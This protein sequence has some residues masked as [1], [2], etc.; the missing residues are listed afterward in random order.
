MKGQSDEEWG[1]EEWGDEEVGK[2]KRVEGRA[3]G[4]G[5][6][7]WREA[8]RWRRRVDGALA[9]SGLTF[10]QWLVLDAIR[11]LVEET[12]DAVNQNPNSLPPRT[13]KRRS[14]DGKSVC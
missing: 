4:S 1:D 12:G 6:L 10:R 9:G 8:Q 14:G 11:S 3:T 2:R 5:K 13:A 7:Q